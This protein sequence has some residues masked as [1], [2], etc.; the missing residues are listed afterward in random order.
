MVKIFIRSF[1]SSSRVQILGKLSK[2]IKNTTPPP[3]K[4]V[5][6]VKPVGSKQQPLASKNSQPETQSLWQSI[7]DTFDAEKREKRQAQLEREIAVGGFYDMQNYTKTQGKIFLPPVSY[8]KADKSLYFPNVIAKNL[9]NEM[10]H[11]TNLFKG[12]TTI[13]RVFSSLEGEIR[14]RG[15][16]QISNSN[17]SFLSSTGLIKLNELYPNTQIVELNLSENNLKHLFVNLAVRNLKTTIPEKRK[18]SYLIGHRSDLT[19]EV[20]DEL[21]MKNVYTCFIYVID[22]DCKIRWLTCGRSNQKEYDMLWKCVK[23]LNEE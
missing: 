12:K 17:D 18:H 21:M 19:S 10:V 6:I 20:K 23:G 8:F 14:N 15:F 4:V 22:K 1:H 16:F 5:S 3:F 9:N 13:L 11:T 7:K 2:T